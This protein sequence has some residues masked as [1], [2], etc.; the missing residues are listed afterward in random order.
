MLN[1]S[2]IYISNLSPFKDQM[3]GQVKDPVMAQVMIKAQV[4][5]QA[6][7]QKKSPSQVITIWDHNLRSHIIKSRPNSMELTM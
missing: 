1:I 4:P 7:D 2:S 3:R 5:D 6:M